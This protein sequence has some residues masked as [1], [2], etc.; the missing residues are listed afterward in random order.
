MIRKITSNIERY[1]ESE[2]NN[3]Q[4]ILL[5][6][7]ALVLSRIFMYATYFL[8]L[9]WAHTTDIV[10]GNIFSALSRL[11]SNW[12][13]TIII[14]GY[15]TEPAY[16]PSSNAANWAFFPLDP[17][18]IKYLC[19]ISPFTI[20]QTAYIFN[21]SVL[22]CALFTFYKYIVLTRNSHKGAFWFVILTAFGPYTFYYSTI[23]TEACFIFFLGLSLY[24][25]KR[26]KYIL[27]GIAGAL[28]SATRNIGAFFIFAILV[29]YIKD[30]YISKDYSFKNIFNVFYNPKMFLGIAL[31][32]LGIFTYMAYLG[33]LMGDPLAFVRI[34][35]A[36]GVPINHPIK[37]LYHSLSNV[38]SE[39][40]YMA[41]WVV[42]AL[43]M[44]FR[45]IVNKRFEEAILLTIFIFIPLS[46]KM[47]SL[48]RY[49][50]C[51]GILNLTF[52]DSIRTWKKENKAILLLSLIIWEHILLLAW[53]NCYG[54][55]A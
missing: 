52:V 17:I 37:L 26:K 16:H 11:D 1:M 28:L 27:M 23:Y 41:L 32:P 39:D 15:H 18:V 34:Q 40:F 2:K 53:F 47:Q 3:K 4:I 42:F 38:G 22:G 25:L 12:Y 13:Q 20:L 30:I 35:I 14:N 8:Y 55:V 45:S 50:V 7:G 46:V 24:L 43:I 49:L 19:K 5:I 21:T 10:D 51:S 6:I 29:E 36:W 54:Y 31:C 48:P 44:V 9:K 33:K